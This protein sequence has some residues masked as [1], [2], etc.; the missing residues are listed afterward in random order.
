MRST[1]EVM[2]IADSFG[3]AFAK[4][5]ISADGSLPLEGAIFRDRE[6]SR[7]A[8]G[9]ADRPSFHEMGFKIYATAGTAKHLRRAAFPPEPV[10]KVYEG[11]PNAIDLMVSGR[12]HL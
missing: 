7:Q 12:I 8:H 1:G 4:S 2:G 9:H 5:Q 3:M 11:R 6:R 10:L